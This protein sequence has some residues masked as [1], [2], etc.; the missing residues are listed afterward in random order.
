M[1]RWWNTGGLGP[2]ETGGEGGLDDL[3]EDNVIM[4]KAL[5]I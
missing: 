3:K 5:D 2:A 4:S 1:W